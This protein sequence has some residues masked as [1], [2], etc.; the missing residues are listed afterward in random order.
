MELELNLS[1]TKHL[2]VHFI[3]AALSGLFC[4]FF[5]QGPLGWGLLIGI[6]G[7]FLIDLDHVLEYFFVF[8]LKFN[9]Q[10]FLKSQQFLKSD[11]I[12]LVLHAYEY[13]PLLILMAYFFRHNQSLF[14]V[15]LTLALSGLV[16][17]LSDSVINNFPIK[18][19]SIIYRASKNFS[20]PRLLRPY[21]W[22]HNLKI[23]KELGL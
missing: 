3:L 16:H 13:F 14:F 22:E 5:L 10:S 19:Y 9:L 21:Q 8:G 18:N 4:A 17:L 15:F 20:A 1:L 11:K 23:K 6:A 12:Y 7:G 2:L